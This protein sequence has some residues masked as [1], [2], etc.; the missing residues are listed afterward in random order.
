M[1]KSPAVKFGLT[2]LTFWMR[3]KS[4]TEEERR[5]LGRACDAAPVFENGAM[6]LLKAAA[7]TCA[8]ADP[9]TDE[10]IGAL[11]AALDGLKAS[12]PDATGRARY[13]WQEGAMA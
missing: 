9:L 7:R 3:G 5:A 4:A 8:S 10:E 11:N 13:Y 12:E 2:C 6:Q 1:T